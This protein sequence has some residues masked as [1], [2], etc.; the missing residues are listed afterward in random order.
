M[1]GM[2]RR[3]IHPRCI[4]NSY[5]NAVTYRVVLGDYCYTYCSM[6]LFLL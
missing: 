5:E 2:P 6:S 4:Y 3:I 1:G